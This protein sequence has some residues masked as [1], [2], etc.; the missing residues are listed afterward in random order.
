MIVPELGPA[1]GHLTAQ[2]DAAPGGRWVRLD[3]LRLE[4]VS[5][6]FELAGTAREFAASGDRA[7]AAAALGRATWL[8]E[9]ERVVAEA[10]ARFVKAVEARLAAA[11]AEARL[12][13]KRRALLALSEADRR[14]I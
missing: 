7:A 9:W 10:T 1:L 6:L 2:P 8:A 13:R 11:A 12:P 4:L 14:A 3:D 5:R